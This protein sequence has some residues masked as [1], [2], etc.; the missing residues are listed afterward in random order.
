MTG[1]PARGNSF[2]S[3]LRKDNAEVGSSRWYVEERV[4]AWSFPGLTEGYLDAGPTEAD[5]RLAVY[6]RSGV[7]QRPELRVS[8]LPYARR[9]AGFRGTAA[10]SGW[11]EKIL[12][13][14]MPTVLANEPGCD[15]LHWLDRTVFRPCCDVHDRCYRKN[16]CGASSW[17]LW[18]SSWQCN[19]CNTYAFFCFAT[20]G[21]PPYYQSPY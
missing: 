10:A 14:V 15:G 13:L 1:A 6:P 4:L 20:G 18:W 5:R 9:H 3:R 7:G 21:R 19:S 2:I 12:G 8:L 11:T 16:G 17:W